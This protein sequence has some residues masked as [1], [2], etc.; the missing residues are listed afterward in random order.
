M[1][2]KTPVVPPDLD[3]R[4]FQYMPLDVV[5]LVDSD[6]VALSSGDE[7]KAAVI[8]WCKSWHQVPASS[9]PDDDRLLAHLAGYGKDVKGWMKVKE[10]ALRNF[11]K[12]PDGRLYHS[13]ITEK[14]I[15]AGE[16]KK[17]QR[18]KT[19]NATEARLQ[20]QRQRDVQRDESNK[21]GRDD[22]RDEPREVDVTS[23]V[24]FTKGREGNRREERK[25]EN[26]SSAAPTAPRDQFDE[27]DAAL[28]RIPGIEKHPVFAAPVIGPIWKLVEQG[29]SLERQIIPSIRKRLQRLNGKAI[30]DWGYFAPGIIEDAKAAEPKTLISKAM[31]EAEWT[32][33]LEAARRMKAWQPSLYGPFPGQPGCRVPPHLLKPDDGQG[34]AEWRPER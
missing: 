33:F 20:K 22:S 11:T 18:E 1:T 10:V 16:A 28:R 4:G 5:R 25:E 2:D 6:L 24:T 26:L 7:F 3:L 12:G 15:E 27:V 34:W 19:A 17:K 23:D 13:V 8:L 21:G 32:D 31:T 9:L 30:S 14:A 29:Y